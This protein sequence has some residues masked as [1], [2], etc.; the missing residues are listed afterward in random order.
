M[1]LKLGIEKLAKEF[2]EGYEDATPMQLFLGCRATIVAGIELALKQEASEM[3]ISAGN[4][5]ML[6]ANSVLCAATI[7]KAMRAVQLEE[8]N[9]QM[10]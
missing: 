2:A 3:A 9:E 4:N 5:A 7:F 8:F 6:T 10:K 1:I